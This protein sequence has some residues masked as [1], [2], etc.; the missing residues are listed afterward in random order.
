M[1]HHAKTLS[2]KVFGRSA[3]IK[4]DDLISSC[5]G[6]LSGNKVRKFKSL[7]NSLSIGSNVLSYG[8]FQSNA[9]LAL[10]KITVAKASRLHYFTNY[11]P[12]QLKS[13]PIG[14]YKHSL[15]MH[16]KVINYPAVVEK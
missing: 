3:L 16:A 12:S 10:S 7:E 11:I 5:I 13:H 1:Q 6:K 4:R 15:E 8:G 9:L 2:A 14:N